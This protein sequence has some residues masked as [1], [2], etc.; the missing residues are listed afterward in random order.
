MRWLESASVLQG[1]TFR[2]VVLIKLQMPDALWVD[3]RDLWQR[4]GRRVLRGQS[5]IRVMAAGHRSERAQGPVQGHGVATLWDVSQTGGREV[6]LP[7]V[8]AGNGISAQRLFDAL[9]RVAGDLGFT[10]TQQ[11]TTG[12]AMTD[13]R[14][15]RIAISPDLDVP[16]ASSA[17]A[18]ELAHLRM[19]KFS[20]GQACT[21]IAELEADSVAYTVLA[22]FG[23][24]G[25]GSP[26]Q[27]VRAAPVLGS[28]P[29][30]RL[31]ETLGGR[32][33]TAAGRLIS[34]TEQHLPS[35]SRT[36]RS[37]AQLVAASTDLT[38][39]QDRQPG[40]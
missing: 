2:N 29:S 31:I 27:L 18:H 39:V 34:A 35:P 9:T 33:V 25:D 26:G 12:E 17:L 15:R 23:R 32:V 37:P 7:S 10:V 22:H 5:G 19:H 11:Q 30:A 4:R 36:G 14:R 1:Q 3:G 16:D 21:G 20:R 8:A 6:G 38:P 28:N 24:L 13:H 40:F